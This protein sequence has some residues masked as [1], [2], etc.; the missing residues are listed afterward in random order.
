MGPTHLISG[1]QAL[2]VCVW[3]GRGHR[4]KS[5]IKAHWRHHCVI[6]MLTV[7]SPQF[8]FFVCLLLFFMGWGGGEC[9][10]VTSRA[11]K[12]SQC[13]CVCGC[14]MYVISGRRVS[15][16]MK[17]PSSCKTQEW[18]GGNKHTQTHN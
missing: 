3:R 4:W 11:W 12:V 8:L 17:S 9:V 13:G 7:F 1:T 18:G 5:Q 6:I 15:I 10:C 14:R 16:L 2:C